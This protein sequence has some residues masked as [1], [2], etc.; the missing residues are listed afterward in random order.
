MGVQASDEDRHATSLNSSINVY[1]Y[2]KSSYVLQ[3][4]DQNKSKHIDLLLYKGH[5]SWIKNFSRFCGQH[6]RDRNY[7]ALKIQCAQR[8]KLA[9]KQ[10]QAQA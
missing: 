10:A 5:Y 3:K 7:V 9:R 6:V 8:C 2:D 1:S 4:S